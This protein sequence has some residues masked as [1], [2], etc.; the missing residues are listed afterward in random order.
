[1]TRNYPSHGK[2]EYLT[3]CN[4][5]IQLF[6]PSYGS[7]LNVLINNSNAVND[8]FIGYNAVDVTKFLR[9]GPKQ[10]YREDWY[11][12]DIYCQGAVGDTVNAV[13]FNM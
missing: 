2:T 11:V 3:I 6:V 4:G 12:M 8:V 10:F 5:A 1:M 9:L 7:R 13:V